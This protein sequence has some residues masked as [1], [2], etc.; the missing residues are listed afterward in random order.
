MHNA[1]RYLA[2]A[3]QH[4]LSPREV[5]LVGDINAQ[6]S[7]QLSIRLEDDP[8]SSSS[9]DGLQWVGAGAA[10]GQL[11]AA[12]QSSAYMQ[13]IEFCQDTG[14][15]TR[16]PGNSLDPFDLTVYGPVVYDL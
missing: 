9:S 15:T 14:L 6:G 3:V 5:Q 10:P 8:P 7:R 16:P 4:L 12:E 2:T 1:R 13:M 11:P